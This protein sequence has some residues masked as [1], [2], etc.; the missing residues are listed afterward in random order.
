MSNLGAVDLKKLQH[1]DH[2]DFQKPEKYLREICEFL[3]NVTIVNNINLS[4]NYKAI[5]GNEAQ[6]FIY[7][8][9]RQFAPNYS[10]PPKFEPGEIQSLFS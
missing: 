7:H 1:L 8:L 4:K 2:M 6:A 10:A 9:I 5:T 3:Q